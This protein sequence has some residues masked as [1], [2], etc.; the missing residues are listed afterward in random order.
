MLC[1]R[2]LVI[3][4]TLVSAVVREESAHAVLAII[5][6]YKQGTLAIQQAGKSLSARVVV[7]C[8]KCPLLRRGELQRHILY[9]N[10]QTE[11]V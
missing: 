3:T 10:R 11:R 5:G 7:L 8:P 4:G 6:V 2:A 9:G 1:L